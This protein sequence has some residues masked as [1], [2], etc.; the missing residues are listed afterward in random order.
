LKID[1]ATELD[2]GPSWG[3]VYLPPTEAALRFHYYF[4]KES[5]D[6]LAVKLK[7]W[8][9]LESNWWDWQFIESLNWSKEPAF[10]AIFKEIFLQS[11]ETQ[12]I[13]N[14]MPTL[15]E[16]DD[17]IVLER[18]TKLLEIS[19]EH[20]DQ[21]LQALILRF[22]GRIIQK[23]KKSSKMR[24]KVYKQSVILSAVCCAAVPGPT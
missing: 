20:S 3:W 18:L 11:K 22:S 8:K 17:P 12:L 9:T 4:P 6:L 1:Y 5:K 23:A 2:D 21:I 13:L 16:K 10:K 7:N 24:K 14:V 19:A 15:G